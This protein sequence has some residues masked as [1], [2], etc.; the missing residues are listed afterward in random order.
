M[1][2]KRKDGSRAPGVRSQRG[3]LQ[4]TFTERIIV[5]GK[6]VCKTRWRSTKLQDTPENLPE[7]IRIRD[8]YKRQAGIRTILD[9]ESLMPT[10]IDSFLEKKKREVRE[11]TM[12]PYKHKCQRISDFFAKV[13]VKEIDTNLVERFLD[14]LYTENNY[15]KKYIKDI[16][17]LFK[18]VMDEAVRYGLV[19]DNPVIGA[20]PDKRIEAAHARYK[21]KSEGFFDVN[22]IQKFFKVTE[23][24]PLS[25]LF[26][27]AFYLALRRE[28]VLG[29]RWRDVDL[30]KG[31]VHI[32][33]TV[34]KGENGPL[35]LDLPKTKA[36]NRRLKMQ[37]NVLS[38]FKR[39]YEQE[40][41][42][43]KLLGNGYVHPESVYVFHHED[44][45]YYYPDYPSQ[46]FQKIIKK[47]PDLPQ[48]VTFHCLRRSC[49]SIL[50]KAG[51]DVKAVQT[52]VGH[53]DPETTTKYY[54]YVKEDKEISEISAGIE[55]IVNENENK[56]KNE[57]EN[58]DENERK[59]E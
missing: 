1:A 52:F 15:S 55:K 3:W 46:A 47:N 9:P 29:I 53:E 56:D 41:K 58:K 38:I 16:R 32:Y 23:D 18:A 48:K 45:S 57:D 10:F 19:A 51:Y 25:D 36:S 27:V 12:G 43:R 34:T 28:E 7:A 50:A 40:Q 6:T 14:S 39:R 26:Q 33:H 17:A 4:V 59:E 5:D 24:H 2:R 35:Y 37:D 31:I 11:S 8:A 44:G 30:Q 21:D 49:I 20:R 13:K 42:Y 22:E 54:V